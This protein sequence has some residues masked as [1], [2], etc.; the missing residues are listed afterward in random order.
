MFN[1]IAKKRYIVQYPNVMGHK[2]NT[3]SATSAAGTAYLF[4]G[5]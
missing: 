3:T 2:S 4:Q 1:K 5:T